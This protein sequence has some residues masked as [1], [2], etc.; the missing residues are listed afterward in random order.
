MNHGW[1]NCRNDL[2][3]HQNEVMMIVYF[4]DPSLSTESKSCYQRLLCSGNFDSRYGWSTRNGY[5]FNSMKWRDE[6]DFIAWEEVIFWKEFDQE[7]FEIFKQKGK[8][9]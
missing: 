5:V 4:R 3:K 8:P 9:A 1:I 7:T 2:P 6:K